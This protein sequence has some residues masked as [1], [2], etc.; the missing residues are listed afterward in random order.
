MG[1]IQG[2]LSMKRIAVL[3]SIKQAITVSY[4]VVY[5]RFQA[6]WLPQVDE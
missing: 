2:C 4:N 6:F 5:H 3:I 1:N